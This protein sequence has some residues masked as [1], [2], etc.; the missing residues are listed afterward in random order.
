MSPSSTYGELN[1][2]GVRLSRSILQQEPLS[3]TTREVEFLE[4][5]LMA[6]LK[7]HLKAGHIHMDARVYANPENN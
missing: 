1:E 2:L 4:H 5:L 6:R 3:L 7:D